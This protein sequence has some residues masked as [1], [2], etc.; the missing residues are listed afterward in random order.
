MWILS[1][2]SVCVHAF[3]VYPRIHF[4]ITWWGWRAYVNTTGT[5]A[6]W[7]WLYVGVRSCV[8]HAYRFYHQLGQFL[9][10]CLINGLPLAPLCRELQ[11]VSSCS[12]FHSLHCVHTKNVF[13]WHAHTPTGAQM[14]VWEDRTRTNNNRIASLSQACC[15]EQKKYG[16]TLDCSCFATFM[17]VWGRLRV[18]VNQTVCFLWL[19]KQR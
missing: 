5:R 14:P 16:R 10:L 12:F 19:Q 2:R 8:F 11:S 18:Y 13:L 3:S 9:S 4:C 7:C 1:C 15:S 17:Q 6:R